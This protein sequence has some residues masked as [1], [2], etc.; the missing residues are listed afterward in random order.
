MT[1]EELLARESIRD[2]LAA[3]NLTGDRG[4]IEAYAATF[5][6][7]GILETAAEKIVGRHSI[8]RY[9]REVAVPNLQKRLSGPPV[10]LRHNLTTSRIEVA[11]SGDAKATTYFFLL[12]Q[13]RIEESGLYIDRFSKAGDRWLIAHRRIKID[14]EMAAAT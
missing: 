6:E 3:Y 1:V 9:V 7:D 2:T 13:G 10:P 14:W 8:V 11:G 5:T 12:R 4:L